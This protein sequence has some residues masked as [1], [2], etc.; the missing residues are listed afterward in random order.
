M[1]RICPTCERLHVTACV[2]GHVHRLTAP[3]AAPTDTGGADLRCCAALTPL[4]GDA[5]PVLCGA[6]VDATAVQYE[7]CCESA[8]AKGDP[9][10]I[11]HR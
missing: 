11:Y 4:P 9:N 2:I 6:R 7:E 3:V 5:G 10:A 8:E 1:I